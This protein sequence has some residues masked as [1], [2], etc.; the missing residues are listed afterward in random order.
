MG[1][2]SRLKIPLNCLAPGLAL[3]SKSSYYRF[4]YCYHHYYYLYYHTVCC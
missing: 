3:L 2:F 4:P 1:L